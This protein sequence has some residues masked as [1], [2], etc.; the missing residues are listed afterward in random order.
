MKQKKNLKKK[1]QSTKEGEIN[2]EWTKKEISQE[3]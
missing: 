3:T 1:R 2:H